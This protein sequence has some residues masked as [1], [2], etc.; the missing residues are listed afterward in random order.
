MR[1]LLEAKIS[2]WKQL[3]TSLGAKRSRTN[4]E[5]AFHFANWVTGYAAEVDASSI[6]IE[7]LSTLKAGGI[8]RRNNNGVAQSAR[9][10]AVDAT[11]HL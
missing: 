1:A 10:K 8:G 2:T 3:R 11:T 4:R 7:D 9:R 6:A 5:P